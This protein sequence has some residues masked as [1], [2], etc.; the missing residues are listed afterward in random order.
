MA[1][2]RCFNLARDTYLYLVSAPVHD[3]LLA[4]AITRRFPQTAPSDTRHPS[5]DVSES[6]PERGGYSCPNLSLLFEAPSY[7]L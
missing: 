2:V 1:Q 5:T 4:V 6:V 7:R 3:L